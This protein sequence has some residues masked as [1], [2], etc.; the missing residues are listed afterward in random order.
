MKPKKNRNIDV[1]RNNSLYFAIG[2]NIMLFLS[3]QMLEHKTYEKQNADLVEVLIINSEEQEEEIPIVKYKSTLPPPAFLSETNAIIVDNQEDVKETIIESS[4][5]NQDSK[6]FQYSSDADTNLNESDYNV[7]EIEEEVNVP[8]AI[9]ANAP[10]FPGCE[11]GTEKERKACFERKIQEHIKKH[12][13]YPEIALNLRIQGKVYVIFEIDSK[14]N[15]TGIKS[16]GPDM[17]LEKEAERIIGLLPKMTPGKQRDR[18]VKVTYVVPIH[19][20]CQ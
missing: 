5:I 12:F 13:D 17:V 3:W 11:N 9:I 10:I 14:G 19:F 16:R 6:I 4:E 7:Q 18:P 2:L 8:F 1:G 20:M 15:I